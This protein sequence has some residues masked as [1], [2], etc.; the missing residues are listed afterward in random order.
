LKGHFSVY[1][2]DG[3]K[4]ADCGALHDAVNIV[5]SRNR[6]WDG[7]YYQFKPVYE[8][9]DVEISKQLPTR[10]IAV[11]MD[12]GVGG[13]RKEVEYVEVGNQKIPVQQKINQSKQEPFIPEFHD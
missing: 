2:P 1:D 7:H 13:S 8:T 3:N 10:D 12:G 6:T 9:V 4:I 5:G 11:N